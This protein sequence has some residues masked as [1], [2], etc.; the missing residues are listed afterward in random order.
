MQMLDLYL[1][2][3]N[4]FCISFTICH[5]LY[6]FLILILYSY[7]WVQRATLLTKWVPYLV[8]IILEVYF[9]FFKIAE[10]PFQKFFYVWIGNFK[11]IQ[12]FLDS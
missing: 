4:L 6:N 10:T 5:V 9:N 8:E 2:L 7:N 1:T 11:H 3:I 12:Y